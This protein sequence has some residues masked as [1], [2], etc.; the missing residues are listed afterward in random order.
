MG[1]Q[2]QLS[3]CP[4]RITSARD[5]R[6]LFPVSLFLTFFSRASDKSELPPLN[7]QPGALSN[8]CELVHSLDPDTINFYGF[9]GL[10]GRKASWGERGHRAPGALVTRSWKPKIFMQWFWLQFSS[11][12]TGL[13]GDILLQQCIKTLTTYYHCESIK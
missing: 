2:R 7:R 12:T 9:A 3:V 6:H 10:Q 4:C 5:C 13:L 1:V 11:T 8:N